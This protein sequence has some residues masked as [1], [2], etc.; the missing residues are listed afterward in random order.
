MTAVS[1]LKE[2]LEGCNRENLFLYN[3]PLFNIEHIKKNIAENRGYSTYP[4]S[5]LYHLA[6][7]I[8]QVVPELNIKITDLNLEMI[9]LASEGVPDIARELKNIIVNDFVHLG[10]Q[11]KLVGISVMFTTSYDSVV[12]FSSFL[13]EL[14]SVIM[15]GG[16]HATFDCE[17]LLR[18]GIADIVVKYCA[19]DS[20]VPVVKLWQN[21]PAEDISSDDNIK[22]ISFINPLKE[23]FDFPAEVAQ[24]SPF[25]I[26]RYLKDIDVQKYSRYGSLSFLSEAVAPGERYFAVQSCRGC[27][28]NCSYCSVRSFHGS[29]PVRRDTEDVVAE[30][31][32]LVE[33]KGVTCIDFLDDDLL[34]NKPEALKLFKS[35][36]RSCKGI[37]WLTNNAVIAA[38]LD[39]ELIEAAVKSGCAH[40]G[41]GIESGNSDRIKDVRK[42]L[43]FEKVR[44]IYNILKTDYSFLY[45]TGNFMVGFPLETFG[46]LM[47]TYAFALELENDWAKLGMTQPLKGTHMYS[48]FSELGD[49]RATNQGS[50]NYSMG[51]EIQ[52]KGF[53]ESMSK[54]KDSGDPFDYPLNYVLSP[55]EIKKIWFI[56]NA[57]INFIYNVN[58]TVRGDVRKF[59]ALVVPI[60]RMYPHDPLIWASLSVAFKIKGDEVN[61]TLYYNKYLEARQ[62]HPAMAAL[63]DELS[64]ERVFDDNEQEMKN[65]AF[66]DNEILKDKFSSLWRN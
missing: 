4:P 25:S 65:K 30:I 57:N 45:V 31:K 8:H 50:M 52:R 19:E 37:K 64:M 26:L 13:K 1:Q 9:K 54:V 3:P 56:I 34:F 47:D 53:S 17:G 28:G 58:L 55:N 15:I 32:F 29:G 20:I 33:H 40:L 43:T 22:N 48:V 44:A 2:L 36:E 6:A 24:T 10:S 14:N 11:R 16:V 38:F 49:S 66:G 35:I 39:K 63:F 21:M 5:G 12:Q 27:R 41:F 51:R 62:Q 42:P 61:Q 59:I 60:S 18:N 46:E 7:A 23:V